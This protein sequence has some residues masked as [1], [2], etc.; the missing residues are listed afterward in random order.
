MSR[1]LGV[2]TGFVVACFVLANIAAAEVILHPH[3]ARP[4]VFFGN[5]VALSA[6]RLVVGAPFDQDNGLYAGAAYVFRLS[7]G[8]WHEEAKLVASDGQPFDQ[9]GEYVAID[10]DWIVVSARRPVNGDG[11]SPGAAY[12]FHRDGSSWTETQRL[13]GETDRDRFGSATAI[14][15]DVLAISAYDAADGY[16]MVYVYRQQDGRWS[17]Q[18][19]IVGTVLSGSFGEALAISDNVLVVGSSVDRTNGRKYS[20]AVYVFRSGGAGWSLEATLTAD[21][22]IGGR[23]FGVAVAVQGGRIVVGAP[24]DSETINQRG[25][26]YVFERSKWTWSQ[27]VKIVPSASNTA[28][29]VGRAVAL[30]DDFLVIGAPTITD[31]ARGPEPGSIYL[32]RYDGAAWALMERLFAPD[33][34]PNDYFGVSVD[35]TAESIAVGAIGNDAKGQDAG[36]SYVFQRSETVPVQSTKW[37]DVKSMYRVRK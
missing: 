23:R 7:G 18:Q 37:T 20:G 27:T 29:L 25:A 19:P 32:Y 1:T 35:L 36:A 16:G 2:A 5:T 13:D 10:G 22:A 31:F 28:D 4:G 15:G 26:V 3:D 12:L 33:A 17:L 8:M 34:H 9:F 24:F 11:N 14:Q 21:D 30:R 6:D